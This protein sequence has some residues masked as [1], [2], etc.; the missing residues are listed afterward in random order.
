MSLV[1]QTFQPDSE[2]IDHVRLESL[3]YLNMSGRKA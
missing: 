3:T 1:G 2:N